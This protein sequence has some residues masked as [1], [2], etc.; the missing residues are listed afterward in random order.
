[1]LNP[2]VQ[3]RKTGL[4]RMLHPTVERARKIGTRNEHKFIQDS[5]PQKEE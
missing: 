1:M 2:T 4:V 5:R 3:E